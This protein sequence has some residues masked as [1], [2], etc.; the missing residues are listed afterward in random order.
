ME[1]ASTTSSIVSFF[2]FFYVLQV[3]GV[4]EGRTDEGRRRATTPAPVIDWQPR[5]KEEATGEDRGQQMKGRR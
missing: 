4:E 1:S 5:P 3:R 2:C